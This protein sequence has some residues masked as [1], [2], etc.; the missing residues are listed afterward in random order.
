MD[1]IYA[2]LGGA[3]EDQAVVRKE[4]ERVAPACRWT[5][6]QWEELGVAWN[7]IQSTPRDIKKLQDALVRAYANAQ[8]VP[9]K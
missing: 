9:R 4:L 3:D 1:R 6:G 8:T 7:E 2:R 5:K